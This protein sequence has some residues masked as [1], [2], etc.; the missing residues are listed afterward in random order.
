MH[1][2]DAAI[3][4][5]LVFI[6]TIILLLVNT[7][8]GKISYFGNY[9]A[10]QTQTYE[11]NKDLRIIKRKKT[12]REIFEKFCYPSKFT[13][14]PPQEFIGRFI[15]PDSKHMNLLGFHRIG[16]GKTCAAITAAEAHLGA[17]SVVTKRVIVVM[18]ASLTPGFRNELRSQCSSFK[19]ISDAERDELK[20]LES[21]SSRY[22]EIINKS[23]D[24]IDTRY[25]ICSYNKFITEGYKFDTSLLII[26]EVQNVSKPGGVCN[27]VLLRYIAA[28]PAMKL[29]VFSATPI[30]DSARELVNL[31]RLMRQDVSYELVDNM[32]TMVEATI[33]AELRNTIGVS[34]GQ[35]EAR[36][37]EHQNEL[38]AAVDGLVSYYRGAPAVTF[39][40]VTMNITVCRMGDFQSEW[41]IAEVEAEMA[42]SGVRHVEI[43]DN[44]Y[45]KSRARSNIVFPKGLS[46]TDGLPLMTAT[47]LT[48]KLPIYSC[49]FAKLIKRLRKGQLSFVYSNF[50]SFGGIKALMKVLKANGWSNFAKHG[51]GRRRFAIWTGSQTANERDIIRNTYNAASNDDASALQIIIGSPSMKEGV[52]LFR[53]RQVHCIEPYWNHSRLEQIY[54]RANRFCSHKSL[55]ASQRT[56][57]IYLYIAIAKSAK[58]TADDLAV[59][60][61]EVINPK[62]SVDAYILSLANRKK[63]I[64]DIILQ[65]VMKAAV[66]NRLGFGG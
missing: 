41:Y 15:G 10:A 11:D 45:I 32:S 34:L 56:L 44:F 1:N 7:L 40:K 59:D 39:P 18:P 3:N 31:L 23:N 4:G 2:F 28:R 27:S 38:A 43:N 66:D 55:P 60:S 21:G 53:T 47:D 24:L 48:T 22:R 46:G 16:A 63:R 25:I 9:T 64:N 20:T 13:L 30:F 51:A 54:G 57:D 62:D 17:N 14:Q 35:A 50:T 19:Y 29:L 37:I 5:I 61:T 49:K 8:F 12:R 6:V 52:S 65:T 42:R 33:N 58:I 36:L 26:D